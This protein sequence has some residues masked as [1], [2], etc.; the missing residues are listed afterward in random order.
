MWAKLE[1][2]DCRLLEDLGLR[3]TLETSGSSAS[4]G[5]TVVVGNKVRGSVGGGRKSIIGT[6]AVGK[7]SGLKAAST[8][9]SALPQPFGEQQQFPVL[10]VKGSSSDAP[11][12]TPSRPGAGPPD[13]VPGSVLSTML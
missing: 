9:S 13:A 11:T 12:S 3:K 2:Y 10:V 5:S 8:S 6:K 7:L 1:V 4:A